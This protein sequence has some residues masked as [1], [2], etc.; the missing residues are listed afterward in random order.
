MKL[1]IRRNQKSGMMGKVIFTLDVMVE[2]SPDEH[3]LVEKYKLH[4]EIVYSDAQASA[5]I[6]AAQ[7]GDMKAIGGHLMDRLAKR[8][9]TVTNL[10]SGQHLECKDL[11]EMIGAEEQVRDACTNLAR[12][13]A[14]AA[15]FDG[16]EEIIHIAA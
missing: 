5:N 15:T 1:K 14:V 9:F 6:S 7:G 10:V 12:Y 2:L 4:K 3:R 11:G 16:S 13:L 8:T